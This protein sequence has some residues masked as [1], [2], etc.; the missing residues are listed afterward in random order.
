MLRRA[1]F[2][3][4]LVFT[5][6]GETEAQEII[7]AGT[8]H[9]SRA[10]CSWGVLDEITA[11]TDSVYVP[12]AQEMVEEG[13]MIAY[14]L[15]LHDYGTAWNVVWYTIASDREAMFEAREELTARVEEQ[16][17]EL[18]FLSWFAERCD[19]HEDEIFV[20]GPHTRGR[21]R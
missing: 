15:L 6:A 13:R 17:P 1:I 18:D 10:K 8:M 4:L 14:G 3:I 21:I 5:L 9:L 20:I 16:Y 12:I 7:E 11:L 2:T 19:E